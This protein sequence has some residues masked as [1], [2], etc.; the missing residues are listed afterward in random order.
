[1]SVLK[2][3]AGQTAIYGISSILG[4]VLNLA[5]TPLYTNIFKDTGDY[6]IVVYFYSLIAMV[7]V[8]LIFGMETTFF[9]ITQDKDDYKKVYTQAFI[10]VLFI[11]SSF[12]IFLG[13]FHQP[14]ASLTGFKDQSSIVLLTLGIIFLDSV[15]AMPMAKLRY[16]EKVT[17]FATINLTNIIIQIGLNFIFILG[18]NKGILFIFV[19]NIIASGIRLVMALWKNTPQTLKPDRSLIHEL[20]MYGF[21][22]MIAQLAGIMTQMLDRQLILK[23][24]E[25]GAI[26]NGIQRTG[27]QML[28]SYGAMYKVAMLIG[29]A[30]QAFR[31]AV[32]P[33]FFKESGNKNSPKTFAR[34]FHYFVLAALTGF[35]FL[36]SFA[37]EIVSFNLFG[38]LNFTFVGESYWDALVVVPILLMAYVF[39]GAYMNLSIWFKITK[40]VRF[41][42]LFT[43]VGVVLTVIINLITIPIF[44]YV[45]SAWATLICF[46][47]MCVMVYIVGQKYYPIPYR[48]GRISLFG[49]IFIIAYLINRQIGPTDGYAP[50][51]FTK[52]AVCGIALG[53]VFLFE[54]FKP[55]YWN[56]EED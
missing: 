16:E 3:L 35:L 15:V 21:F 8:A 52:L 22:I 34:V 46:A 18:M 33:F 37:K 30:T 25:D 20:V 44:G 9:R 47:T 26:F 40:Q 12:F 54:K 5:L 51:F 1:M 2:K 55:I 42:I 23:V 38:L 36:A 24:W 4:R 13:A 50:A 43:G 27:E 7:N 45:G 6:G 56:R 41:A 49:V 39:Q 28:G 31:Y 29:L 53:I 32:E 14:I 10:W 48:I 17:W 19:A 11:S